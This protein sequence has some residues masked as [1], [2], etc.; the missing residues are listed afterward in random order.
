MPSTGKKPPDESR[1]GEVVQEFLTGDE[2][3]WTVVYRSGVP[4]L[5]A[6][7]A[8]LS[9][10]PA[11]LGDY[12]WDVRK[13]SGGPSV[14][15]S[16]D[17]AVGY[18]RSFGDN[19]VEPIV[20]IQDH[21]GC[22]PQMLPHLLQEFSLYHNLW[23]ADCGE[24]KKLYGDGTVEVACEVSESLVRVRT[25]LLRQFQAAA[26]VVLVRYVDSALNSDSI[27][28]DPVLE[29]DY[30]GGDHYLHLWV[31]GN[32]RT[33]DWSSLLMGKKVILPPPRSECGESPFG[34]Q[35][36]VVYPEFV[37]GE[38]AEGEPIK[39]TCD[40]DALGDYFGGN[41]DALNYVTPVYFALDVLDRYYTDP[42]YDVSDGHLTCGGLWSMRL[43]NNHPDHVMVWLGDLGRGLPE[44]ERHHWLARNIVVPEGAPSQTAIR[45]DILGEW[46]EADSPAWRLQQA[47]ARFRARWAATWSWDLLRDPD[48]GEPGLLASLRVPPREGDAEFCEQVH[49][50]HKLLVESLN[51]TQMK[52]EL[53]KGEADE[54]SISLLERWLTDK[55]HQQPTQDIGF[56]RKIHDLRGVCVHRSG[57]KRA[58]KFREHSI[59]DDRQRAIAAIFEDAISFLD[60]LGAITRVGT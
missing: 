16:S 40:P 31:R 12:K 7:F 57:D 47:Y 10:V 1:Q 54:K 30:R 9:S 11:I 27:C 34:P 55:G 14:C 53:P 22:L 41:P 24:Y 20:I 48:K 4:G 6:G 56:L 45:R 32:A 51:T 37:V 8:P 35:G 19:G 43:D 28:D 36:D 49:V 38:T 42:K 58:R 13:A 26:Q 17:G 50:I 39:S 33:G 60:S 3:P 25:K 21:L 29:H 23:H 15:W 59:D 2:G 52:S 18:E 44:R 5:F 46:A